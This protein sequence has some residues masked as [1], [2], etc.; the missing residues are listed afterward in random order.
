MFLTRLVSAFYDNLSK[1]PIVMVKNSYLPNNTV[2]LVCYN[3][4]EVLTGFD[5]VSC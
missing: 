4:R 3:W 2:S 1:H 5:V